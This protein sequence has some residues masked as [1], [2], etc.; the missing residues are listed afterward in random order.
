MET[1]L[2]WTHIL[3]LGASI[4]LT[5]W[6]ARTLHKNGRIFLVD[7]FHG[8]EPLALAFERIAERV[9]SGGHDAPRQVVER[10]HAA[11]LANLRRIEDAP[12]DEVCVFGN[13]GSTARL[14]AWRRDRRWRWMDPLAK[15]LLG[16]G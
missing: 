15:T 13:T 4:V 8:N 5:V 7:A 14:I 2:I 10:R 1:Y 9:R 3:Y 11:G 6:V 16:R 12:F